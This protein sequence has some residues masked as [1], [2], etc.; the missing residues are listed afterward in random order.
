M[1][2]LCSF[3]LLTNFVVAT[4][5]MLILIKQINGIKGTAKQLNIIKVI[6]KVFSQEQYAC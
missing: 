1:C 4:K 6:F 2:D 3:M 5:N